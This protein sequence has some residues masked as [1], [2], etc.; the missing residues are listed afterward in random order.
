RGTSLAAIAARVGG[1]TAQGVLHHFGTKE[2]LLLEVLRA[3]QREFATVREGQTPDG[4]AAHLRTVVEMMKAKPGI[5]QSM[6]VL[7][8][9]SVTDG[10]PAHDF[11]VERYAGLRSLFS[12][13]LAR[14]LGDPLPGGLSAE[15]AA[16][17]LIAMLD[18]LR[19]QWLLDPE[20]VDIAARMDDFLAV[21]APGL[22]DGRG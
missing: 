19:L 17:L 1:I 10:H 21:L 2:A 20:R 13:E 22:A 12:T 4:F 8:A 18:G 14:E 7:S 16:T 6:M 9:D 11:F 15:S 3:R 5:P